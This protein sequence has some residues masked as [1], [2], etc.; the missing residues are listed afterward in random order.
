MSGRDFFVNHP[1]Q[2]APRIGNPVRPADAYNPLRELGRKPFEP[3]CVRHA[4][5]V[6]KRYHIALR[7]SQPKTD[8]LD[9]LDH[10]GATA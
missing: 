8:Q 2:Q 1:C 7:D 10:M 6:R 4:V 5:S 3:S 9:L